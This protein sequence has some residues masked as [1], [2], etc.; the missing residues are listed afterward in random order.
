M[1]TLLEERW[2]QVASTWEPTNDTERAL[3]AA[4]EADDIPT[5]AR[6]VMSAPL[7]R[8]TVGGHSEIVAFTSPESLRTVM[9]D[10]GGHTEADFGTLP[11]LPF[12]LNPGLP[13]A[14]AMPLSEFRALADGVVNPLSTSEMRAAV[15]DGIN[16]EV[17]KACL[18]ELGD[19]SAP[20]EA[21]PASE[22]ERKLIVA[23]AKRDSDEF[24]EALLVAEVV[25]PVMGPVPEP[26]HG[27]FP[28]R[29]IPMGAQP[30]LTM[31]SSSDLL[32]RTGSPDVP[33]ESVLFLDVLAS[34]PE[35]DHMLCLDPGSRTEM[36]LPGEAVAGLID[37]IAEAL[38][39][40]VPDS[41]GN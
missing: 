4:L 10:R 35:D 16:S 8:P 15:I 11:E 34:W 13:I 28:W 9:G 30:V 19:G 21:E 22:L 26:G 29:P 14:A 5:F 32:D 2:R 41:E 3:V 6:I 24:I 7:F 36:I 31:F 18:A 39:G 17:R 23:A 12:V 33:R 38:A 20:A 37:S 1:G 40:T 27:D 25:V